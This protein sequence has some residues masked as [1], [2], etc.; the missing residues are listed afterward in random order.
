MKHSHQHRYAED[1][2]VIKFLSISPGALHEMALASK[3]CLTISRRV[4]IFGHD[5]KKNAI[6]KSAMKELCSHASL[7]HEFEVLCYAFAKNEEFGCK[8]QAV[9]VSVCDTRSEAK[10]LLVELT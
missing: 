4:R 2:N 10:R 6:S 5:A 3:K 9:S 7:G 1:M 8:L